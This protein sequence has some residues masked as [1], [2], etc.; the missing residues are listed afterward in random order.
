[1][2]ITND[3]YLWGEPAIRPGEQCKLPQW[4][5]PAT[6]GFDAFCVLKFKTLHVGLLCKFVISH[7]IVTHSSSVRSSQANQCESRVSLWRTANTQT[8]YQWHIAAHKYVFSN[9]SFDKLRSLLATVT[10][11]VTNI[12]YAAAT[13][14]KHHF[15]LN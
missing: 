14:G 5:P 15:K 13:S 1:M 7:S 2:W 3:K 4:G 8:A 11:R 12:V 6:K 10:G 9:L